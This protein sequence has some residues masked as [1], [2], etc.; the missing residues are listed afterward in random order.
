MGFLIHS[1]KGV[2]IDRSQAF[3]GTGISVQTRVGSQ[4]IQINL[5]WNSK[6]QHYTA[7]IITSDHLRLLR[8]YPEP[9]EFH[10]VNNFDPSSLR[11]PDAKVGI[12]DKGVGE[13]GITPETIGKRHFP[14]FI[15][16]KEV[17]L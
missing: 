8:F 13:E 16:G 12:I 10:L 6:F 2:Q 3:S 17:N 14:Y 9:N 4:R 15:R 7:D 5:D 1:Q 11:A